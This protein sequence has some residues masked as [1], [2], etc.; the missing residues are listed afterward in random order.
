[1]ILFASYVSQHFFGQTGSSRTVLG[2]SHE[3][4]LTKTLTFPWQ[5]LQT[6]CFLIVLSQVVHFDCTGRTGNCLKHAYFLSFCIN[7]RILITQVCY[8]IFV[9]LFL[10][11]SVFVVLFVVVLFLCLLSFRCFCILLLGF[12]SVLFRLAPDS[13]RVQFVFRFPCCL[14]ASLSLLLSYGCVCLLLCYLCFFI[15]LFFPSLFFAF[16]SPFCLGAS[17]LF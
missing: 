15:A 6:V 13:L 2:G 1:M 3:P 16:F 7:Y 9:A 14:F 11:F 12:V 4:N 5:C 17:Y 10:C 8:S